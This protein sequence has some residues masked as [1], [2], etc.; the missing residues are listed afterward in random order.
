VAASAGWHREQGTGVETTRLQYRVGLDTLPVR[1]GPQTTWTAAWSWRDVAYGTGDRLA[2]PQLESAVTH[3]LG[4]TA[5]VRLAY[6]RLVPLGVSPLA[7]DA[8]DPEDV[9]DELSLQYQNTIPRAE[10]ITTTF[11]ATVAYDYLALAPSVGVSYGERLARSF[12]WDIGGR[13]NLVTRAVTLLADVGT[14]LGT[15]TYVTVRGKY[16]TAT[17]LFEDLDYMLTAQIEGCF[18]LAVTY[19]QIRQEVWVSLGLAA[20]PQARVQFQLPGP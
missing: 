4:D 6:R 11:A 1:L 7:V 16:N 3:S 19:R 12:H 15:D 13:Y 17:T 10:G 8:V 9:T 20:F 14:A 5:V 18:E 2:V